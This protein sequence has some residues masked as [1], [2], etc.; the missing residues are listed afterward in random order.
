[1]ARALRLISVLSLVVALVAFVLAPAVVP[2]SAFADSGGGGF[3][4]AAN[5][6]PNPV[7]DQCPK[8]SSTSKAQCEDT[9][10]CQTVIRSCACHWD[11]TKQECFCPK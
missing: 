3:T 10:I 8:W 2:E 1:M 5:G 4:P 11:A 9:P 6:C 7:N